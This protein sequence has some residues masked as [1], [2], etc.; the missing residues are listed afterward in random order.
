M[1]FRTPDEAV[2]SPTTRAMASPRACGARPSTSPSTSRRK[3]KAGVVWVN[4]TNLFDAGAG[5]GGY[6]ESGFGR[7]G[8]REG[9]YEYL[10][11]KAWARPRSRGAADAAAP[12]PSSRAPRARPAAPSTGPPSSLSAA[13][14]RGPMAAI[15]ARSLVAEGRA[16]RRS[17]RRQPQGHPQRRRGGARPR[18]AGRRRPRTTARRFSTTS[19]RTCRPRADEFAAPHRAMTGRRRRGRAPRSTPRS[20]GCSPTPPGPTNMRAPCMRRRCA[21]SPWR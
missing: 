5:F 10:K 11:P 3:L 17:R 2:S 6:R 13:S 7:E 9:L 16:P 19:P 4:S 18:R 21:A 14:R 1:T 8:G 15:P 20:T 12:A